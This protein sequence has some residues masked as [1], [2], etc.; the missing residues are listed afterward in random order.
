MLRDKR[1]DAICRAGVAVML[2]LA[3]LLW[4]VVEPVRGDGSHAIGYENRLFDQSVVHTIDIT[5]DDWDSFVA[6]AT[7]EEYTECNVVIDG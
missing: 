4:G 5:M 1:I 7:A 2:A 6:N 3:I